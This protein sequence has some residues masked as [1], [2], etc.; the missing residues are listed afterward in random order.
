MSQITVLLKTLKKELRAQGI[1]YAQVATRLDLSHSSIKRLF[2]G[3]K[4]SLE[5]LEQLCQ[6]V[7]WEFSDLVQKTGEQRQQIDR[8]TEDQEREVADDPLLLLVAICVLNH[9][10]F[11]EIIT[12]YEITEHECIQ[13]LARLDRLKLIDLL[14]LNR[15]RLTVASDFQWI[16]NGPIQRFF[17]R[18]IQPTFMK[19][20]F[21]GPGE[22][23]VFRSGMLSRGSNAV[24]MK[25]IERL[26]AEFNEL[27]DEDTQLPLE[28]RYGSSL[29]VAMRP[30]EFDYFH[31]LRRHAQEK[32]F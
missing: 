19:S 13:L 11:D 17:R 15:F 6:I 4:L 26:V 16:P 25:K 23:M 12:I 22:K 5:R 30:W 28:E 10:S 14:P 21:S 29:L 8:L 1:T 24:L 27:H 18:E 3:S 9:W 32:V 31:N 7:G 20:T 2:S